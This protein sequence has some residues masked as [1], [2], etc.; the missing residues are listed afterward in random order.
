M[1]NSTRSRLSS[2][3]DLRLDGDVESG[4]R[5][6]GHEEI[7]PATQG[8]RDH[9]SLL[10]SSAKLMRVIEHALL[11]VDNADCGQAAN[12]LGVD[13]LNFRAV[14]LNCFGDL[15]AD[16]IDRVERRGRFLKDVGDTSATDGAK[17]FYVHLENM[18]AAKND[19]AVENLRRR[20][21]QQAGQREGG[22]ALATS[23]FADNRQGG[24]F[25]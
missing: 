3:E 11:G 9:R 18:F 16:G 22:D 6:V 12:D 21:R 1:P 13:I 4:R 23:A 5:F 10:H 19:I 15:A 14:Q 17:V 25:F 8:H 2:V 24:S 7:W 20:L